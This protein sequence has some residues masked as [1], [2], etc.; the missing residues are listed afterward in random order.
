MAFAL[1]VLATS[2]PA[3]A[4]CGS[5]SC[6]LM[7][8]RYAEGHAESHPGWSG[9]VRFEFID[10][11]R[12]RSGTSTLKASE[13]DEEEIERHTRN[14]NLVT[15]L[16]YGFDRDWS[17]SLRIPLTHRDHLHD[18]RDESTGLPGEA[19]KWRFTRLGDVQLIARRQFA[20]GSGPDSYAVFGGLKLPTGSTHVT[21]G[22]GDHAERALQPGSG[23]TDLVLGLAGRHVIDASNALIGQTSVT[24]SLHSHEG[25]KPGMRTELSAGWSHAYTHALGTVLQLNVRHRDR[26]RG[27]EAEPDNSGSTSVDVSPGITLGVGPTSTMYAYVQVPVYQKVRGIQL[28]PRASFVVG[29]TSDF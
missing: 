18:L 25:Y 20:T 17:I 22:D 15:T 9:D 3:L 26:D 14:R 5:T 27:A 16:A 28:V 29:L 12:L 2:L 24:Q 8:D 21:N 1:C 11:K 6:T 10:Q 19:E 13:V 23:T 4:S 7:T